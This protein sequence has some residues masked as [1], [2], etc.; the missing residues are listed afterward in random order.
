MTA[1]TSEYDRPAVD[2]D[3]VRVK[4]HSTAPQYQQRHRKS[5]DSSFEPRSVLSGRD[6]DGRGA[7][8]Y[9]E[10]T[11]PVH[12]HREPA[13]SPVDAGGQRV[14]TLDVGQAIAGLV[15]LRSILSDRQWL[16]AAVTQVDEARLGLHGE[17]VHGAEWG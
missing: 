9:A 14:A 4:E 8:V 15:G 1:R 10:P 2:L 11:H 3:G 12:A 7:R 17:A 5:P 6:G 16:S 13:V